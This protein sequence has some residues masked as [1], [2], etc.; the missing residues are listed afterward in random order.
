VLFLFFSLPWENNETLL[1]RKKKRPKGLPL[2]VRPS[3]FLRKE[4]FLIERNIEETVKGTTSGS[5]F[6]RRKESFKIF[7]ERKELK[8]RR[9][10]G[11]QT[12]PINFMK[13]GGKSSCLLKRRNLVHLRVSRQD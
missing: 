8:F 2:P 11:S 3:K 7:Q 1:S 10:S 4:I 12:L 13:R 6:F 9:N 5:I